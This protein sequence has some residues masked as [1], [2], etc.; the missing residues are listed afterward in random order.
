MQTLRIATQPFPEF[1]AASST[2]SDPCQQASTSLDDVMVAN[3]VSLE[4]LAARHGVPLMSLGS[5]S[6][7]AHLKIIPQILTAT[8][9]TSCTFA[10][11]ADSDWRL[12][13]A[14]ASVVMEI[15]QST[16]ELVGGFSS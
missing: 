7:P 3:A 9:G 2:T 1:L 6:D 4:G 12:A 11:P 10:L 16:G 15:A 5:S 13:H 14:V 8:T